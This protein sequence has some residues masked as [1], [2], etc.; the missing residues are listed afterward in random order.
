MMNSGLHHT[1][2]ASAGRRPREHAG[3]KVLLVLVRSAA[4]RDTR[5]RRARQRAQAGEIEGAA[6][7]APS[8][9]VFQRPDARDENH[10]Q[11]TTRE[12]KPERL[13]TGTDAPG[14]HAPK[15]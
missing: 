12:G 9:A 8:K 6:P 4:W 11:V 7:Y 13:I 5:P 3:Y 15:S 2:S 10:G 14:Q 1:S